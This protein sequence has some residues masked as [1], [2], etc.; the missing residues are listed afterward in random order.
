MRRFSWILLLLIAPSVAH[1]ADEK[2]TYAEKDFRP[3]VFSV[4]G[5]VPDDARRAEMWTAAAAVLAPRVELQGAFQFGEDPAAGLGL[6]QARVDLRVEILRPRAHFP[7]AIYAGAGYQA[8]AIINHAV[9]GVVV[10]TA[11]LG[12]LQ[13]TTNVRLA[14]YVAPGRDPVDVSVTAGALVKATSWLRVGAEY[15]G[16]ELEGVGG[17]DGDDAIGGRHYVGPTA[18]LFL[19]HSRLRINATG[20]AVMV[21]GQTGALVRGSLAYLF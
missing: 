9:T 13:L 21:P 17:P 5:S 18:V 15:V 19:A 16:E 4:D 7:V 3:Y 2:D 10:A 8:D 12:R 11:Y 6:N 20:G 1:A 14:H